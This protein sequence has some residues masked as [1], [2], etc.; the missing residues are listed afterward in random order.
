MSHSKTETSG[1]LY[2]VIHNTGGGTTQSNIDE[3]QNPHLPVK[4][5]AHYL[6]GQDSGGTYRVVQMVREKHKAY[7][8]GK[9]RPVRGQ[10]INNSNSI[11]IEIVGNSTDR[12]WPP[13][14]VYQV[15]ADLVED[16]V[17]RAKANNRQIELTRTYIVGHDEI[18][19][20]GKIDPGPGWN[21][22][23]FM[24]RLGGEYAPAIN[25]TVTLSRVRLV[26]D[27]QL[28]W[29]ATHNLEGYIVERSEDRGSYKEIRRIDTN[30]RGGNM[31]DCPQPTRP[32]TYCYRVWSYLR[33]S[34]PDKQPFR[35][36][37]PSL[38][39]PKQ[40]RAETCQRRLPLHRER[41]GL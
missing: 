14:A 36:A 35:N 25:L 27:V 23:E 22:R 11:G 26:Q 20:V 5:S 34:M 19:A 12:S 38:E 1:P 4:K 24:A 33:V 21:W 40:R 16:I 30:S 9:V 17:R 32:T 41:A 2:V 31:I 10:S 3:F 8:T 6:V 18:S 39:S 37:N 13:S 28:R 7:H 29:T 15:V